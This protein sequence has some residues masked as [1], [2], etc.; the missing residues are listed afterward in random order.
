[1][2]RPP[3]S[4][5][6]WA[7]ASST[8]TP[9]E[10]G[11]AAE[12]AA[13]G[14][15]HEALDRA[16]LLGAD[17][18]EERRV[19]GVDRQQPRPRRLGQRRGQLA[20]DHEAL[21]VGERDVDPLAERDDRRPQAGRADDPVE[22]EV[23]AGAG[24]QL[25]DPLLA[26]EHAAA[27]GAAR[28]LGGL[29]I[30]ERD[31]RHAVLP[32]LLEQPLPARARRQADDLELLGR[33]DDLQRLRADRPGRPENHDLLHRTTEHREGR[34]SDTSLRFPVYMAGNHELVASRRAGR[35][36]SSRRRP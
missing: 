11:A 3:I 24:D 16:R 5:V 27:P 7:R 9:D 33:G 34:R 21:L 14:G 28:P 32:R 36:G 31:G 30:G 35:R 19:L 8:L 17:Q 1:M 15:Q 12:G 25:A 13:G 23:G 26:G 6:G 10:V 20:A 18:L 29:G 4:Q 2:I 22:D